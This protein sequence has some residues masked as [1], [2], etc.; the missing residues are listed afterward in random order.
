MILTFRFKFLLAYKCAHLRWKETS[1]FSNDYFFWLV[2]FL[3]NLDWAI[4]LFHLFDTDIWKYDLTFDLKVK[5]RWTIMSS[6]FDLLYAFEIWTKGAES[7][8]Y[9]SPNMANVI[10]WPLKSKYKVKVI[11]LSFIYPSWNIHIFHDKT[12]SVQRMV[13]MWVM[14]APL[15]K[16]L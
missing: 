6:Y 5:I 16:S 9:I 8:L 11:Y 2:C 13:P 10:L 4:T 12:F 14:P 7:R 15:T 3:Y 1:C